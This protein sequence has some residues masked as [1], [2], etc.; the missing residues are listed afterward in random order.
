LETLSI[1]S[2][3][4]GWGDGDGFGFVTEGDAIAVALTGGMWT[5]F[6][7]LENPLI[8]NE[9]GNQGIRRKTIGDPVF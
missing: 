1:D 7:A 8:A 3:L 9:S 5:P 4:A 2:L 6:D